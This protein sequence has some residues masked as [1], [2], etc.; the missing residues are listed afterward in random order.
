MIELNAQSPLHGGERRFSAWHSSSQWLFVVDVLLKVVSR[1]EVM[2]TVIQLLQISDSQIERENLFLRE[3]GK[4]QF[5]LFP[6]YCYQRLISN[7]S[8][9]FHSTLPIF[10]S[11]LGYHAE[12]EEGK[13]QTEWL[14]KEGCRCG[15][16][17]KEW[18]GK[19]GSGSYCE[20]FLITIF[21]LA[22]PS[23][24]S[25]SKQTFHLLHISTLNKKYF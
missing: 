22:N 16:G 18:W 25:M 6:R 15:E 2:P 11:D 8:F 14:G 21:F 12:M 24:W 4:T 13:N 20:D 3:G 19:D 9:F 17:R 10:L 5:S 7:L 1:E 23:D